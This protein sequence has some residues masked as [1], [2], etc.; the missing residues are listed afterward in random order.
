MSDRLLVS[1]RKGLFALERG[2]NGWHVNPPSFI[3]ENVS[4][5]LVDSRDGGWYAALSLGHFGVKLKFSP[6]QGKTW[7]D[8]AVPAYPEGATIATADGK[9]PAPATLKG[10]WSLET[11][12]TKNAGELWCGTTPGGLFRSD[13]GG[14]SW[15]LVRGLW[16]APDRQKWFGGGTEFPAIHS[17]CVDPRDTNTVRVAVSCGGVWKTM[18]G[19]A[20]WTVTADGMFADYMPPELKGD[21]AIQDPHRMVQCAGQ[22]DNLWVQHHNGVFRT[23]DGGAK[24]EFV[25]DI[26]P[27]VFGF[28][29]AVHPKE[30]NTAWFVPAVK[31][32][33]RVPVDGKLVVTRTRDGGKSFDVLTNGLPDKDSFDLVYRHAL[34]IDATGNRLAMGSTTGGLWI[35]EDQGDHWQDIPARL[36]PIHAVRFA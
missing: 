15:D 35:T 5:A 36:P 34:D 17:I 23:T 8:R 4:L 29:V 3:G 21:P 33:C 12:G 13:D 27:S 25:P 31:D 26:K 10:I 20:T 32:E 7:E 2:A 9:P 14:K 1:S 19:G 16:D 22:P 18:D 6:D 30:A 11:R 28:S 24:W